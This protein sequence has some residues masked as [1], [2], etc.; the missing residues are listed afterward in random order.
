M[1]QRFLDHG[2]A[3]VAEVYTRGPARVQLLKKDPRGWHTFHDLF[4]QHSAKGSAYTMRGVQLKRRTV[5]EVADEMAAITAPVLVMVGDEDETCLEPALVMKRRIPNAGLWV[6]PKSGHPINLE[7][8][9]LFNSAVL[10][11]FT[12]VEQERWQPRGEVSTS[13]LPKDAHA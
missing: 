8:P 7:E 6:F 9:A 12:A 4:V 13:L 11:F 3:S 1:A 10:D 5:F 2:T